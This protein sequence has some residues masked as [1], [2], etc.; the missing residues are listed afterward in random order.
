MKQID[1]KKRLIFT[2]V[3][4]SVTAVAMVFFILH[5]FG[6][7][8]SDKK[9]GETARNNGARVYAFIKDYTVEKGLE[10]EESDFSFTA[11]VDDAAGVMTLTIRFNDNNKVISVRPY[12]VTKTGYQTNVTRGGEALALQRLS[13]NGNTAIAVYTLTGEGAVI[14]SNFIVTERT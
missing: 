5:S 3:L 10:I 9:D 7:I 13:Y 6:V 11:E 4:V 14:I 8:G 1:D 12:G 2:I